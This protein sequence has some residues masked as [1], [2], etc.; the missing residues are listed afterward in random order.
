MGKT[1]HAGRALKG[2]QHYLQNLVNDYPDYLNCLIYSASPSLCSQAIDMP[3]WVSPL[4]NDDYIEYYDDGFLLALEQQRLITQLM[5]FWPKNGPVW[6][7][8]VTVKLKEGSKGVILL[9]AKSYIG[10]LGGLI[11]HCHAKDKSLEKINSKLNTVK[12]A[13]GVNRDHDWLGDYYQFANRLAH[14][15]FFNSIAKVPAWLVY[16]HFV[17]DIEQGGPATVSEWLKPISLLKER[18]GLPQDHVL[19]N[20]IITIFSPV[21]SGTTS[22][23]KLK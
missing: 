15:Y 4:K 23:T 8:L 17:G 16:L 9:E 6:D 3:S 10:E 22:N 20:K 19:C 18:L 11:Y 7:A 5:D 1:K 14:L 21:I 13:L 2:S 12:D